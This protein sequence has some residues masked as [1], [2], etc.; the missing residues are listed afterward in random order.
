VGHGPSST[1][2]VDPPRGLVDSPS[3][4]ISPTAD[5]DCP[6]P[7]GTVASA[8]FMGMSTAMLGVSGFETS[9]QFIESMGSGKQLV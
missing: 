2:A 5:R 4:L 6:Q 9:A 8:L 7:P 1:S 3:V